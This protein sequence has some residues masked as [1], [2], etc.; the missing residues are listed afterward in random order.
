MFLYWRKEA[1]L[2]QYKPALKDYLGVHLIK[3]ML[4]ESFLKLLLIVLFNLL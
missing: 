1:N 2:S 4:D 3:V